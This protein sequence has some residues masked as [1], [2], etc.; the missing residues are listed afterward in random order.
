MV[1]STTKI[2]QRQQI[3]LQNVHYFYAPMLHS[4][5]STSSYLSPFSS[6]NYIM[7][8]AIAKN[9]FNKILLNNLNLMTKLIL[10]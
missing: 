8:V 2:H 3:Q 5:A 1:N 7:H 4:S 10:F 6:P 9:L